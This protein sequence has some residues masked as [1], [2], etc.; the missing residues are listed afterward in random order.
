M[1]RLALF[2]ILIALAIAPLRMAGT[3]EA[4]AAPGH[5]AMHH[6]GAPHDAAEQAPDGDA[7]PK[8]DCMTA[9]AAIAPAAGA[10]VAGLD[11]AP[12]PVAA[13]LSHPPAGLD[14]EAEPPPPRLS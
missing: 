14:P 12:Q 8:T 5:H 11:P 6:A 2:L 13:R 9:C 4:A 3:G 10:E 1:A 7:A